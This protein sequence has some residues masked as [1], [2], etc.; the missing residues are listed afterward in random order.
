MNITVETVRYVA[1]LARLS[2]TPEE[3]M[4]LTCQLREMLN[5]VEQLGR[6]EIREVSGMSGKG[7]SGEGFREDAAILSLTREDILRNAPEHD[8]E[9]FLVP[10][11]LE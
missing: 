7:K 4:H 6:M 1:A 10:P 8:G 9:A 3:E 11:V 2:F 5:Y